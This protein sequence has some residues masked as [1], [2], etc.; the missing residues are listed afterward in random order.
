MNGTDT[1]IRAST[2]INSYTLS[3]WPIGHNIPSILRRKNKYTGLTICLRA[4]YE[5][6]ITNF[7]FNLR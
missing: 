1:V 4:G 6:D 5:A 2:G 7:N 3:G